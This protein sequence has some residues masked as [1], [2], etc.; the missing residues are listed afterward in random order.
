M[1][2]YLIVWGIFEISTSE[3]TVSSP[4]QTYFNQTL[5]FYYQVLAFVAFR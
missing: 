5:L 1:I 2:G 4:L 3:R